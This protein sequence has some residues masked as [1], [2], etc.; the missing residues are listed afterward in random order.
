LANASIWEVKSRSE[1]D[2]EST[3]RALGETAEQD[4]PTRDTARPRDSRR[5][6]VE[7]SFFTRRLTLS[8]RVLGFAVMA[9]E[10]RRPQTPVP[11]AG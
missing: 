9:A 4:A 11:E 8:E 2:Q 10:R 5:M 3:E 7:R 1:S 6:R